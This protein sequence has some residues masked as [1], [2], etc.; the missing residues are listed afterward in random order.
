[1]FGGQQV[2]VDP[3]SGEPSFKFFNDFWVLDLATA[4]WSNPSRGGAGSGGKMKQK[5]KNGQKIGGVKV[6]KRNAH[7]AVYVCEKSSEEEGG[8]SHNMYVIGGS[9]ETGPQSD[10]FILNLDTLVWS[11]MTTKGEQV[12]PSEMHAIVACN[13]NIFL[14]GGR[15]VEGIHDSFYHLNVTTKEWGVL[16]RSPGRCAHTA[17]LAFPH[18]FLPTPSP[19]AES[20]IKLSALSTL[21]P[22]STPQ[23]KTQGHTQDKPQVKEVTEKHTKEGK[24]DVKDTK[25]SLS[26]LPSLASLRIEKAERDGE[27]IMQAQREPRLAFFGGM[28]RREQE[29]GR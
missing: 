16:G 29:R 4:N 6:P 9:N 26:A 7:T 12:Q 28:M 13:T 22:S 25:N 24:E 3:H 14:I 15:G 1:M 19:S 2:L 17:F 5:K 18:T 27:D 8:L 21:S 23:E 10:V 20:L 11:R